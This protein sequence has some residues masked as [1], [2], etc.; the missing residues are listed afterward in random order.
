MLY[1]KEDKVNRRLMFSCR[2]CVHEQAAD[3]SCV[4]R[5]EIVKTTACVAVCAQIVSSAARVW[6]CCDATLVCDVSTQLN[7]IPTDVVQDP[8]LQRGKGVTCSKCGGNDA[9]FFQAKG[10]QSSETR[11]AIIFVCCECKTRWQ[12]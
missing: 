12:G 8:T 1:P 3:V 2:N 5:H 10:S 9:V 4:Y 6:L 7:T 11:M